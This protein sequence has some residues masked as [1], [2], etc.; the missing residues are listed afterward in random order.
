MIITQGDTTMKTKKKP[1]EIT[2]ELL[3]SVLNE[4][5]RLIN[6]RIRRKRPFTRHVIEE[7]RDTLRWVAHDLVELDEKQDL[8]GE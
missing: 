6:D 3:A 5:C 8:I 4:E 7:L 2:P 1:L